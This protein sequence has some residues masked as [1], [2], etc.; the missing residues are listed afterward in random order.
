MQATLMPTTPTPAPTAW[1]EWCLNS[2]LDRYNC[3]TEGP[4]GLQGGKVTLIFRH[5]VISVG[6]DLAPVLAEQRL[7][8]ARAEGAEYLACEAQRHPDGTDP[9]VI[10]AAVA[11][12]L[13]READAILAEIQAACGAKVDR[14]VMLTQINHELPTA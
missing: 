6:G 10:R 1:D 2:G 4:L 3:T 7:H 14:L 11:A 9:A 8:A 12:A 5:P 13:Q